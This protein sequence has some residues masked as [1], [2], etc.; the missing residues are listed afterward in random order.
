MSS[1]VS[2]NILCGGSE[3][4]A[5]SQTVAAAMAPTPPNRTMP[6]VALMISY[7]VLTRSRPGVE[8]E[9]RRGYSCGAALA[10]VA[11]H[12][13]LSLQSPS[14]HFEIVVIHDDTQSDDEIAALHAVGARTHRVGRGQRQALCLSQT[15]SGPASIRTHAIPKSVCNS[16]GPNPSEEFNNPSVEF[17]DAAI[18]AE[19]YLV[20]PWRFAEYDVA[21][22]F[23][24]D[25]YIKPDASHFRKFELAISEFLASGLENVFFHEPM[26][27]T[28]RGYVCTQGGFFVL[29]PSLE[30]YLQLMG[31]LIYG[32]RG[33]AEGWG[34]S[35]NASL[36]FVNRT[37][38]LGATPP[39]RR[40]FGRHNF[41]RHSSVALSNDA[42]QPP[43]TFF[44]AETDQGIL[45][46][47][48]WH[49]R[50]PRSGL[51][52]KPSFIYHFNS[53][54][55]KPQR[56]Y[57][58]VDDWCREARGAQYNLAHHRRGSN[59]SSDPAVRLDQMARRTSIALAGLTGARRACEAAGQAGAAEELSWCS[60]NMAK[61]LECATRSEQAESRQTG[62]PRGQEDASGVL[63]KRP[64]LQNSTLFRAG[65]GWSEYFAE[66]YGGGRGAGVGSDPSFF[67]RLEM[68]YW[69][70]ATAKLERPPPFTC[71]PPTEDGV[72]PAGRP[73]LPAS[74]QQAL[75][76]GNGDPAV[77]LTA[78]V[79]SFSATASPENVGRQVL[80]MLMHPSRAARRNHS[81]VEVTR[82]A[83]D[84]LG[85]R[86]PDGTPFAEGAS[87]G[88]P[89][90]TGEGV[91]RG[92]YGFAPEATNSSADL[93]PYGC[94]L[95]PARGSGVFVNVGRTL[96][97]STR[98][99]AHTA[100]GIPCSRSNFGC[101]HPGDKLYCTRAM[102]R[103]YDSIQIMRGRGGLRRAELLLC[104]GCTAEPVRGACLPVETR[105][106]THAQAPCKCDPSRPIIN[107]GT[108]VAPH[109]D[110]SQ[111]CAALRHWTP[112]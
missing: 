98:R 110:C 34:G 57:G 1:C 12:R 81:W 6:A 10:W 79:T 47:L 83:A 103:G 72:D 85:L 89:D 68:L 104:T 38:Q 48:F 29:R 58:A 23:D 101:Y 97:V 44:G 92:D 25:V 60:R 109:F 17:N 93:F 105:T 42:L 52:P 13:N 88:F 11:L 2:D 18:V 65:D 96:V 61:R 24:T 45:T 21:V 66:V 37:M 4:T 32:F 31:G 41:G 3:R 106:G 51:A 53:G 19:L 108:A 30:V 62:R 67:Q 107:C 102:A 87:R 40:D 94:W 69:P 46:W 27:K 55:C 100:L 39:P 82:V 54:C 15:T 36:S 9:S 91:H 49:Q 7:S 20:E 28:P 8:E 70:L 43:W 77:A 71:F 59:S 22:F 78:L 76:S 86:Y 95:F 84:C 33:A 112:S 90:D 35:G 50:A 64:S 99:D 14:H 74:A 5:V 75:C 26:C 63:Q 56:L 111:D 80:G 16:S 73:C